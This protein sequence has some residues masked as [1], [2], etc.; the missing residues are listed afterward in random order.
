LLTGIFFAFL[1][2]CVIY[3]V[4]LYRNRQLKNKKEQEER[5]TLYRQE[6][7]KTQIEIQ[8]QT[9]ENISKEIHDNVTQVLSFIK[10]TL[11]PLGSALD[12][13]RKAKLNE[14]RELLSQTI[15]DLRDLSKSMSF[16]HIKSIGLA[17]TIEK[18]VERMNKSGIIDVHF[19]KKGEAY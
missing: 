7:L 13:S 16:E 2:G 6:I 18:E 11:G 15:N 4:I 8:E 19:S 10:L 14:S 9:L 12:E 17:K 1:V 3:F 5:E